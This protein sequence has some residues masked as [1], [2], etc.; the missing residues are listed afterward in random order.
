MCD[1]RQKHVTTLYSV[2]NKDLNSN[3]KYNNSTI[4]SNDR[5]Y[6]AIKIHSNFTYSPY[7][8]TCNT[9]HLCLFDVRNLS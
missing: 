9:R 7:L 4:N 8:V 1:Y 6:S 3:K 2:L 5:I